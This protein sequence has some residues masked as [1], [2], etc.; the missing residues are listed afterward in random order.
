MGHALPQLIGGCAQRYFQMHHNC[1]S[2][3]LNTLPVQ[4]PAGLSMRVKSIWP[5]GPSPSRSPS[6]RCSRPPARQEDRTAR[7]RHQNHVGLAG[8]S[9]PS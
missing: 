4:W 3:M 1:P 5:P 8:A 7:P 2:M 9:V 6:C